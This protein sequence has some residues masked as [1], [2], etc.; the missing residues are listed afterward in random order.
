MKRTVYNLPYRSEP[1]VVVTS[2][3]A[4]ATNLL[5]IAWKGLNSSDLTTARNFHRILGAAIQEMELAG[6][7]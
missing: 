6:V 4:G 2:T 7:V 3:A 5:T 1:Y